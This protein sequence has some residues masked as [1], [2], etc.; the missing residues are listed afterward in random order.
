MGKIKPRAIIFDLGST[1]I[2]YETMPWDEMGIVCLE[3][4]RQYMIEKGYELPGREAVQELYNDIRADY[5]REAIESCIEWDVPTV[6]SRMF[7]ALNI[8]YDDNLIDA[9]FDAYYAPVDRELYIYD[10]T[11]E[12][13]EALK[14]AYP[15]MG[16]VSNT[17]FP[18]RTH[19]YELTRFEIR[20][21]LKFTIFS[22]TFGLRKPHEDIFYKACNLAGFAPSECLYVGDRYIEDVVGPT[23]IGMMSILKIK[24]GRTYPNDMPESLITIDKLSELLDHLELP[25]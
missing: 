25:S 8:A 2:E 4:A 19:L 16:L 10:D 3:A 23:K 7:D 1:L 21:Y 12:T 13:L 6:A 15:V 24:P 18:E 22:S 9:F 17:V 20:K 5:R 11:I 14:P